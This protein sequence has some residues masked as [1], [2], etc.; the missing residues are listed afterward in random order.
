MKL[1]VGTDIGAYQF[2]PGAPGT[3]TITITGMPP[4]AIE[5]VLLVID[6]AQGVIIYNPS[7]PNTNGALT[8]NGSLAANILTLD[9]DTSA[10]SSSDN[11]QIWVSLAID[12]VDTVPTA[13]TPAIS[14]Q[15]PV[16]V[17]MPV[18]LVNEQIN[19]FQ[20]KTISL[21]NPP[22]GSLLAFQDCLQY[23]SAAVQI[24]TTAGL[25]A[26]TIQFEGS[27][28]L[29]SADNW[30]V[31]QFVDMAST[32]VGVS[33]FV[34]TASA[35]KYFLVATSLRYFRVRITAAVTGGA[36]VAC[37][38]VYRMT[39]WSSPVGPVSTNTAQIGGTTVV[40]GGIAGIQATGGNIAPG[41][42]PTAY[43]LPMGSVDY[44]GLTRRILTD[45][46]GHQVIAGPDPSRIASTAPLYNV[47][48]DDLRGRMNT[49]EALELI[50]GELRAI[51]YYL[52]ELPLLLNQ[53]NGQFG[54]D[55]AVDFV[56][57][58]DYN[59]NI[60]GE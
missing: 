50:L 43:P 56:N 4:I 49:P 12:P 47:S 53:P 16:G 23:R 27:N 35:R 55:G 25:T 28:G 29:D 24:D 60:Q 9:S 32:S 31:L 36:A 10:L 7:V 52:H 26:G 40:T 34:L 14:G 59:K 37:S 30:C 45:A 3:G 44:G 17:G 22:V 38:P 1:L 6:A 46:Q 39:P 19:D 13:V 8:Y 18:A 54:N 57:T 42:A 41:A 58:A 15:Q 5:D 48:A 21:Y 33:N 51:A 11:L 20:G 2:S